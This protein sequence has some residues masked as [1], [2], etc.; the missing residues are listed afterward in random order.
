MVAPPP[1]T[2]PPP[3]VQTVF[4]AKRRYANR[5]ISGSGAMPC[6]LLIAILAIAFDK[7]PVLNKW[8]DFWCGFLFR[9]AY[10]IAF[11]GLIGM[12]GHLTH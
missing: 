11:I 3:P 10:I 12:I 5:G 6:P 7:S 4:W 8:R 1:V 9:L 2:S